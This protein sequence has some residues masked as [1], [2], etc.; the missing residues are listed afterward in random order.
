LRNDIT[1]D[2]NFIVYV[3]AIPEASSFHTNEKIEVSMYVIHGEN[4]EVFP[5]DDIES[6]VKGSNSA[7]SNITLTIAAGLVH[8]IIEVEKYL[9]YLNEAVDSILVN[10]WNK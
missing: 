1:T 8:D 2:S 7:G 4:D 5:I 3:T 9:P 10:I 6:S